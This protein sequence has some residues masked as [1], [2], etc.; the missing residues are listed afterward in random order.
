VYPHSRHTHLASHKTLN[1]MHYKLAGDW[2]RRH[3]ADEALILNADR[4]VSET[5]TANVCCVSGATACFPASE[6]ALPGT[7]AAEVRRLLPGWGFTVQERPLTLEE[8]L[9]AAREERLLAT[10]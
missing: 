7:M 5:N 8:L 4:T 6:H 2:A 10:A 1:Y 3:G 9:A